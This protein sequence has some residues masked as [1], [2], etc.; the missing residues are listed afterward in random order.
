MARQENVDAVVAAI[1]TV[2]RNAGSKRPAKA[3]I[4]AESG[5][6]HKTFYRIL[7]EHPEVKHQIELAEAVFDRRPNLDNADAAIDPLKANPVAA[8]S[9]LLD[10]IAKLTEVIES[11]RKWIRTL[12]R[13]L[14]PVSPSIAAQ[15]ARAAETDTVRPSF[16]NKKT[17]QA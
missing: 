2:Y 12:E 5:V 9:E 6:A 14:K 16:R 11:Q 1:V 13:Q 15:G 10:T 4:V 3:E 8:I 7:N 17:G